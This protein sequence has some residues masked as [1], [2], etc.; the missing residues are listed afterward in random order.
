[1]P[2]SVKR[3]GNKVWIEGVE[4]EAGRGKG[5]QCTFTAEGTD[6]VGGVEGVGVGAEGS[7]TITPE[8]NIEN[9]F[10][11]YSWGVNTPPELFFGDPTVFDCGQDGEATVTSP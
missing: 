9:F 8:G 11:Q 6:T 5:Q 7:F 1:M 2:T 4:K 10:M 3:E